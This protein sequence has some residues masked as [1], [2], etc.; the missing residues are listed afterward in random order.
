MGKSIT[1]FAVIVIV[2]WTI[3]LCAVDQMNFSRP[4]LMG[5]LTI[6]ATS[7]AALIMGL[8]AVGLEPIKAYPWIMGGLAVEMFIPLILLIYAKFSPNLLENSGDLVIIMKYFLAFF[9]VCLIL[10]K[11]LVLREIKSNNTTDTKNE[12]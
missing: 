8:C 1:I 9:P 7:F 2:F 12:R 11:T 10:E 3:I 4:F 6:A 5:S